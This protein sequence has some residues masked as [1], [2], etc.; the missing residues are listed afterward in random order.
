[1]STRV[2]HSPWPYVWMLFGAM[3][4]ACMAVLTAE[5]RDSAAWQ[6]IAAAR[7]GLAML[8]AAG[9][10]LAAGVRFLIFRPRTLWMRSLAGSVSLLC[11]FFAMTHYDVAVVLTLTNMYPLWVAVLSWPLLGVLPRRDTWFAALFGVIG[12]AVLA[13]SFEPPSAIDGASS[14]SVNG[15]MD[16]GSRAM[17]GTEL[18]ALGAAVVSAFTS[19]VALIGLHRLRELD[20]RAVVVH[21][22]GVSF[23]VCL[24]ALGTLP[25]VPERLVWTADAGWM[26]LGIGCSAT[27]GQLLLTRAFAL[28]DPSRVSVVGL[29]Q[30]GFAMALTSF[31]H[32]RTYSISTL[33]GMGLVLVP[34]AWVLLRGGAEDRAI[35]RAPTNAGSAGHLH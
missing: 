12:V 14:P 6:W 10:V 29:T 23:C 9:L 2:S 32:A 5:L 8:F 35:R 26:F 20:A 19:A 4:F 3:A 31:F 34:T 11:G 7:S 17:S 28:G 33:T 22:S 13:T 15:G 24:I 16:A 25:R 18:A 30:T 27:V 21:F 1:M